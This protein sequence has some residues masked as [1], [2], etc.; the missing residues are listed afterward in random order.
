MQCNARPTS[1]KLPTSI[2]AEAEAEA[3]LFLFETPLNDLL[4]PPPPPPLRRGGGGYGGH[5]IVDPAAAAHHLAVHVT[6]PQDERDE[7]DAEPVDRVR[8]DAGYAAHPV[9]A[10]RPPDG[11]L[12]QLR[13]GE[14]HP[15][16]ALHVAQVL[17]Q[18]LGLLQERRDDVVVD[19]VDL[20]LPCRPRDGRAQL[21]EGALAPL[22]GRGADG[23]E[24]VVLFF[25]VCYDKPVLLVSVGMHGTAGFQ[26]VILVALG[27][28]LLVEVSCDG[29]ALLGGLFSGTP[30]WGRHQC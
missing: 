21:V 15:P 3:E 24:V 23:L 11:H 5:G 7:L 29:F 14:E 28:G 18:L 22:A 10:R 12:L 13:L 6:E 19:V 27:N 20:G 1:A 25:L 16:Q 4:P 17:L 26:V 8:V 30:D 2:P 9:D